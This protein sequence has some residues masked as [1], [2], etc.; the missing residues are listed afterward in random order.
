MTEI[1]RLRWID[2]V[3]RA[4]CVMS[5]LHYGRQTRIGQFSQGVCMMA[6]MTAEFLQKNK[7][8][9]DEIE[10]AAIEILNAKELSRIQ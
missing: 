8:G 2:L 6:S 7:A 3:S 5:D 9:L 1:E 10:C 4:I